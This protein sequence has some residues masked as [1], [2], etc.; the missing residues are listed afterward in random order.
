M[1]E[2]GGSRKRDGQHRKAVLSPLFQNKYILRRQSFYTQSKILNHQMEG[3]ST[4][5]EMAGGKEEPI[6]QKGDG[7]RGECAVCK[8]RFMIYFKIFKK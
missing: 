3:F 1:G 5:G 4:V 8:T 2:G 6:T 7:G